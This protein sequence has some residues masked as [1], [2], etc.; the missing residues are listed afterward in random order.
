MFRWLALLPL[1]ALVACSNAVSSPNM[2]GAARQPGIELLSGTHRVVLATAEGDIVLELYA[3][4]APKAVTNFVELA[5]TGF[6]DDLTFHRVIPNFI[7]QGGDPRGDGTGGA[8]IFGRPFEDEPND[9]LMERGAVAMANHGPNTNLSQ[10][11]IVQR[12]DGAPWLQGKHTIFGKVVEG[13]DIV[14]R[15]ARVET[16]GN[17]VPNSPILFTANTI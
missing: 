5:K 7:I 8:S 4:K 11:F 13:M 14:D 16:K 17:D 2:H 3:D 15:I 1:A 12:K 6:Y 10:F 9:L